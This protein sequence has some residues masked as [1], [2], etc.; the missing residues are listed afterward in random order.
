MRQWGR[1]GSALLR[2]RT[3]HSTHTSARVTKETAPA[4][5]PE[6]EEPPLE[7]VEAA[8]EE[9]EEPRLEVG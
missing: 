4:P 8:E 1:T 5:D 9:A 2:E 3:I 7:L 6:E